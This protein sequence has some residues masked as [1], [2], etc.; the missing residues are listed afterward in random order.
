VLLNFATNSRDAM[1]E[2]G[3]LTVRTEAVTIDS[4]FIRTHGFGAEG[5]YACITVSDTGMGMDA[6]TSQ[7]IFEPFFT[8]KGVG[9]G[10]GLGMSIVYGIVTQH[11]GFVKCRS[12]LGR[13]TELSVYLPLLRQDG[14]VEEGLEEPSRPAGGHETVLV[15]DDDE[16]TRKVFRRILEGFGYTVIE[17][18]DGDEVVRRFVEESEQI[19]LLLLDA[20][21][22]R[23]SGLDALEEIRRIRPDA[24][25]VF[26]TGHVED[27]PRRL[28]I[29]EAGVP[30]IQK[31]VRPRELVTLLRK[32]LDGSE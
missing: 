18:R 30:L 13:G 24:K 5:D 1:P 8:T 21:M 28:A 12:E 25:A 2:G 20:V 6:A 19:D 27:S 22:P 32:A 31:P 9:R 17:A 10:T 26:V 23:R 16:A 11:R 14:A 4:E 29:R 7:R 3:V 15:A